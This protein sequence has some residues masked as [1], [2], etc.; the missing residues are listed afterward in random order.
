MGPRSG[1]RGNRAGQASGRARSSLQW[2]RDLEIAEMAKRTQGN[3]FAA[4][5][6]WGR[7]LEIAEI[8]A[9]RACARW[10]VY[11]FNGAAI[12]RSRK[13]SGSGAVERIHCASMG[14]RSGDRGNKRADRWGERNEFASM[15]PRSG[16]RGNRL[17]G[18]GCV[19]A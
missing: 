5:L 1:D 6:Q 7:D 11:R 17:P 10:P 13:L 3:S 14:P 15:G 18:V 2:G 12:W 9:A 16:D 19:H 8:P 4:W